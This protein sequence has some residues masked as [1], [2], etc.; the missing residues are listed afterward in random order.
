MFLCVIIRLSDGF[1]TNFKTKV[2]SISDVTNNK[3]YKN[4]TKLESRGL[5]PHGKIILFYT[6]K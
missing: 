6:L 2:D 3:L 5:L 4:V 1:K